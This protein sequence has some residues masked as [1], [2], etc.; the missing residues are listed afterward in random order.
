MTLVLL[1]P[2]PNPV[3]YSSYTGQPAMNWLLHTCICTCMYAAVHVLY[4]TLR[5][6]TA[7]NF[8]P[9][10]LPQG[11]QRPCG[12]GPR[13]LRPCLP[14]PR[15]SP[16]LPPAQGPHCHRERRTREWLDPR[17]VL[18]RPPKPAYTS[19]WY[20]TVRMDVL[21]QSSRDQPHATNEAVF[22]VLA[23]ISSE[24]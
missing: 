3:R 7:T 1:C 24:E 4:C 14:L 13:Q 20:I 11:P 17:V 18:P 9:S 2:S 19:R 10:A 6:R 23:G 5:V 21:S 16:P 8:P 15:P 12:H 22:A